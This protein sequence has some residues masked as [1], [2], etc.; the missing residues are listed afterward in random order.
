MSGLGMI[1]Y[2]AA[3][4]GIFYFLLIRPQQK[5]TKELKS[6]RDGVSIGDEIVTI[7]GV[8]AKVKMISNDDITI[9]I[10][11]ENTIIIKK[12]AVGSVI[13]SVSEKM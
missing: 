2:V 3:F 5:K 8:L 4:L 12:W 7:G 13:D 9:E 10:G 1:V 11:E 6:M